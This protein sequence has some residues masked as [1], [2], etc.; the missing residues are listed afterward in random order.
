MYPYDKAY[1]PITNV[2]SVEGATAYDNL[3]THAT[4]ILVFYEALFYG[5][6]LDHILINPN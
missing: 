3:I 4:F 6:K 1:K 5:K 2:P